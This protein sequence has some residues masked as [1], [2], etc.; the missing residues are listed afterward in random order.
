MKLVRVFKLKLQIS[1]FKFQ[2]TNFQASHPDRAP[3]QQ[4]QQIFFQQICVG[5][6]H[7][8]PASDAK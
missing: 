3:M 8:R 4:M 5:Q 2:I 7:S 1:N 6:T